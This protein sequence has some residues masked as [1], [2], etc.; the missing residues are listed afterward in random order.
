MAH[1]TAGTRHHMGHHTFDADQAD[2]LE[3][4][5]RRYE[6]LSAEEL[7]WAVDASAEDVLVDLGSGTGFYTDVVAPDAG[8]V[9]AVDVQPA[10]HE[11][12]R[13]KGV[14]E[15]VVLLAAGVDD[16][17]LE[18]DSV[19]RAVSTMTYHEFATD[20]AIAEVARVLG[21][22]GRLAIVDWAATGTGDRGPPLAERFDAETAG[23]T[24]QEGGFKVEH[25]AVRPETFL[26]IATVE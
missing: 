11:Y 19:D 3:R 5:E 12:Y 1:D 24:L 18:D 13:E 20:A 21:A 16:L 23:N 14:P 2:R 17:P 6:V 15:S 26:L 22:G 7:R 9:Y 4:P 25:T 10:M 8:H